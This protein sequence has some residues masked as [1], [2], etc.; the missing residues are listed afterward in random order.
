MILR[1]SSTVTVPLAESIVRFPETVSIS[2]PLITILSNLADPTVERM[3]PLTVKLSSI[4]VVPPAESIVKLPVDAVS[5]T[6]LTLPTK[7]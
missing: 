3:L 6:H 1:L 2:F 5:Y 4:V 7:A